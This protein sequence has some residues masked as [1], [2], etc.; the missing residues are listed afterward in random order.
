[1]ASKLAH[2]TDLPR[3]T[4][5]LLRCCFACSRLERPRIRCALVTS[6]RA[7]SST[8]G[9]TARVSTPLP[10]QTSRR[11]TLCLPTANQRRHW[12]SVSMCLSY[13]SAPCAPWSL[14]LSMN[15]LNTNHN[16]NS[17]SQ[18][19]VKGCEEGEGEGEGDESKAQ[20]V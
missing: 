5:L 7:S 3:G 2:G 8:A 19:R 20:Q 16:D 18:D 11:C 13:L 6:T 10:I 9:S 1:V 4:P 17:S 12:P 15:L 14:S